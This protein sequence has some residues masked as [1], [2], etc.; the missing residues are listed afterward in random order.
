VQ[1]I[2]MPQDMF[3]DLRPFVPF[4]TGQGWLFALLVIGVG[5]PLAEELLF[6]GFLMSSLAST[7]FG[8]LGASIIS[9]ALWAAL[10]AGYSLAG[11]AEV[12][13]IGLFFCWLLWRTGSL[14][15]TIFCHAIY[16][17]LIVVLL[18]YIPLPA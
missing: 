12:F 13:L 2:T 10:H 17:S 4:M 3:V 7:R 18:R 14:W 15:V 5:A 6:R 1:Y 16:N 9:T 8:F 11:V